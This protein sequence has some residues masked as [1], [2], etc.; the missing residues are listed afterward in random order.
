VDDCQAISKLRIGTARDL[1]GLHFFLAL[2]RESLSLG[3]LAYVNAIFD[4][5]GDQ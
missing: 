5:A 3:L 1:T 4:A 2:T